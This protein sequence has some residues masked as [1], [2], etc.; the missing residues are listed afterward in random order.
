MDVAATQY[1]LG[2]R[3]VLEGLVIDPCIPSDWREFRVSRIYR[4]CRL[5]IHAVNPDGIQHGVKEIRVDGRLLDK[6]LIPPE[7][8]AGRES[9]EVEVILG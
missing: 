6:N 2:I 4:G 1:L 7:L 5:N 8:I 9:A 3:P